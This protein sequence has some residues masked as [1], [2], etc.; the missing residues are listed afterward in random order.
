MEQVRRLR[1]FAGPNGSG[2]TSLIHE[3]AK[4]YTPQGAF[5]LHRYI[6]ADDILAGLRHATGCEFNSFG[7][8]VKFDR[9]MD[10]LLGSSRLS[11]D[12]IKSAQ[13]SVQSGRLFAVKEHCDSYLSAA[14]SDYL[15]ESL[16]ASNRSFAFE[17]VMSHPNKVEFLNRAQ[18]NGF[19]TYLYFVATDFPQLNVQRVANRAKLGGH[20]VP[21]NKIEQRFVRSLE[22]L[23]S[24]LA[25]ADRAFLFDNSGQQNCWLAELMPDRRMELKVPHSQLPAWF[26]KYVPE[27]LH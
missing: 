13:L 15:R 4:E 20:D 24:A 6:N 3:L 23:P 9:L 18:A 19:R 8:N 22:L 2:K 27:S 17:T 14:I 1:M 5:R 21:K 16:L 12:K 7:E 26:V 11:P 10:S 25:N